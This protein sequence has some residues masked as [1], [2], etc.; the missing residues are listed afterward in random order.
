MVAVVAITA[1]VAAGCSD[2]GNSVAPLPSESGTFPAAQSTAADTVIVST[3]ATPATTPVTAPVTT[4]ASWGVDSTPATATDSSDPAGPADSATSTS[5]T[6][7]TSEDSTMAPST[8]VPGGVVGLSA[9]GPWRLVD[10]APGVNSP[11]LVYELMP[12]LWVFLPT[13]E[14]KDDGTLFVPSPN[15]IPIIE[16]YLQAMLVY[17]RASSSRPID[18]A[19]PGWKDHFGD[20]GESYLRFLT[21]K[22]ADDEYVDL[23]IG[24]VLRPRVIGDGRTDFTAVVF[25]CV[26][27]GSVFRRS[28]ESLAVGSTQGVIRTGLASPITLGDS[29]WLVDFVTNQEDACV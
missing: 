29:G 11:G 15:D 12:K 18:L 16:A 17:F 20:G 21:P 25:D 7:T 13:E 14:S 28:D 26:L 4:A 22:E 8:V 19:D 9:D 27:D 10:S 6:S 2:G 23:D 24:V 5:E 1:V 3:T